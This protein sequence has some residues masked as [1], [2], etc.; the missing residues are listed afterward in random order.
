MNEGTLSETATRLKEFTVPYGREIVLENI[1]YENGMQVLRMRIREGNR[2]TVMD[3]DP[4]SAAQL[5]LA[6]CDWAKDTSP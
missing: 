2:F 5:G 1:E 4:D 3:L 6:L